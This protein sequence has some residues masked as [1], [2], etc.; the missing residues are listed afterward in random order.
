MLDIMRMTS[1]EVDGAARLAVDDEGGCAAL[2]DPRRSRTPD[3]PIGPTGTGAVRLDHVVVAEAVV[4]EHQA[5]VLDEDADA[6]VLGAGGEQ[7][8]ARTGGAVDRGRAGPSSGRRGRRRP[9][10]AS[11]VIGGR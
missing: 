1:G 7:H 10:P 5:V 11:G 6:R 8:A 2:A 9:A 3:A 4:V